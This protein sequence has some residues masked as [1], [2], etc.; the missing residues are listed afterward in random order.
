MAGNIHRMTPALDTAVVQHLVL[1]G[2]SWSYYEQTLREIGSQ[3]IS[4]A[5]LDGVMELR[6]PLPEHEGV[7]DAIGHLTVTLT[8][9]WGIP[10]KSFGSATFRQEDKAAGGEPDGCFY[11]H[12]ID[13]VRGM[14]RFDPLIHRPPDLWIEVDLLNPSVP[15]EPI[16]AAGSA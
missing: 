16:C 15:R 1:T 5:F 11:F 4:V 10:R 12:E 7:K 6:S 14:K 13:S 8:T 3:S 9:E 2:V